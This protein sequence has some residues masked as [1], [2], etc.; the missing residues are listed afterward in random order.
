MKDEAFLECQALEKRC[1]SLETQ[2]QRLNELEES[3]RHSAMNM[4]VSHVSSL[5][6]YASKSYL[7]TLQ[8]PLETGKIRVS[9]FKNVVTGHLKIHGFVDQL[10]ILFFAQWLASSHVTMM[11]CSC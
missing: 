2:C 5:A 3:Q 10:T 7:N 8:N 4:Q 11:S 1:E 6:A 9:T